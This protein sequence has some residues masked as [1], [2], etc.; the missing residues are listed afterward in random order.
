MKLFYISNSRIPTGKAHG[1]QIMK[2]CEAF[3]NAGSK[4][5]LVLPRKLNLMRRDPFEYYNVSKSFEI[6]YLFSIDLGGR[7]S[8]FG[9][10]FFFLD[11]VIFDIAVF[12]YSRK[13]A[14]GFFYT[15]DFSIPFFLPRKNRI[16]VE[17]HDIPRHDFLFV[18]SLTRADLII[19]ITNGLKDALIKRGM[20]AEKIV[21]SP[22]AVDV[23]S[24]SIDI[25]GEEAR[26]FLGLPLDK[27]IVM[28]IGALED[29]KGYETLLSASR[30][31]E[32]RKDIMFVIIGGA[33]EHLKKLRAIYPDVIFTGYRPYS[34]LVRNQKAADILVIPNSGK[35]EISKHYTSPLKLFAHMLSGVPMIVS[36]LPSMREVVNEKNCL[37]FQP[38][39]ENDLANKIVT[40]FNDPIL[41]RSLAEHAQ[42]DGKQYSWKKRAEN[43][44]ETISSSL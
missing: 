20:S 43:I 32:S 41:S 23:N 36:D 44:T 18:R 17:I 21:V 28:Y 27:K 42:A 11:T 37:F 30:I 6:K 24:F 12:F 8:F 33:V 16:V 1:L 15:R 3:S 38:D 19:V 13:Q 22:D 14:D 10:L 35:R 9:P 26:K 4:V 40:L 5:T 31:L 39:D 29:W 7:A 34:E 25:S 2:M